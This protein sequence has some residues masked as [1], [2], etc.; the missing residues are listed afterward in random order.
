[1]RVQLFVVDVLVAICERRPGTIHSFDRRKQEKWLLMNDWCL[2][3]LGIDL[4]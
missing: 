2:K 1:M 4:G 3:D